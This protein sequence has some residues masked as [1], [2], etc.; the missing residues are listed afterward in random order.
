QPIGPLYL[1][2]VP[3]RAEYEHAAATASAAKCSVHR[4]DNMAEE[5]ATLLSRG[6][7]VARFADREEFGARALGNRAILADPSC[8]DVLR[9]INRAIKSR[10]F[11][12][13]FACSIMEDEAEAFVDNPKRV[14]A[15]YMIMTFDARDVDKIIA[16]CHPEDHS[17]RPQIVAKE[18]N[19]EYYQII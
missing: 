16:G 13:P 15:P 10:D 12:M 2:L 17:V 1:G 4:P 7:I 9:S 18:W 5:M 3:S 14:S 6:E 8:T 19:S 11:W